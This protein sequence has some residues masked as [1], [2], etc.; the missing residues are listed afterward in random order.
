MKINLNL[1]IISQKK[2]KA[3]FKLKPIIFKNLAPFQ[4]LVLFFI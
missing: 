4:K 3:N 1:T 2:L